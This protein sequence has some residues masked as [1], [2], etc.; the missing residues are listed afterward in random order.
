M[1]DTGES[2]LP[3]YLVFM[4]G[5]IFFESHRDSIYTYP[6]S[7]INDP[8]EMLPVPKNGIYNVENL[9]KEVK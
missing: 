3:L 2:V 9:P 7:G 6:E 8:I 5:H 4:T 1:A